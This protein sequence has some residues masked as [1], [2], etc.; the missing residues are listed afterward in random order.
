VLALAGLSAVLVQLADSSRSHLD[1]FVIFWAS[2]HVLASGGNPYDGAEL[3][4]AERMAHWTEP[5]AYRMWNPP[6]ILPLL[7]PTGPPALPAGAGRMVPSPASHDRRRC[8]H[9]VAPFGGTQTR[10]GMAWLLPFALA[11]TPIAWRTGQVTPMVL[12]GLAAFAAAIRR[13]RDLAAGAALALVAIKP[14]LVFLLWPALAVWVVLRRRWHVAL[15][16]ALAIVALTAAATVLRP[17]IV[18]EFVASLG[19]APPHHPT[20]TIGTVLRLAS[21]RFLGGDHFALVA[22]APTAGV[23]WLIYAWYRRHASWCWVDELPVMVL[24]CLV[25]APFA[26]LYD[27]VLAVL[28]LLQVAVLADRTAQRPPRSALVG[29]LVFDV[30]V[31][32]MNLARVNPFW[33]VW[34]PGALLGLYALARRRLADPRSEPA[35]FDQ[36]LGERT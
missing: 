32:A 10:R 3:L 34:T 13:E 23:L 5:T 31:L 20:S 29:L 35:R 17:H 14:H 36:P 33:Y 16:F 15:G 25:L 4:A 24:V 8:G 19:T 12:F 11:P 27:E 7:V 2:G 6:W 22:V 21:Q 30:C 9:L 26:W 28:P 1:D 18:E